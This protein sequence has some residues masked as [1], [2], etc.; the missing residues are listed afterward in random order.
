[1]YGSL[2]TSKCQNIYVC[3]IIE[4]DLLCLFSFRYE[5]WDYVLEELVTQLYDL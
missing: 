5:L 4:D 1:M 2:Y 3:L